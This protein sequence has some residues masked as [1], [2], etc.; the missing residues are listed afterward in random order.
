MDM[1]RIISNKTKDARK[2]AKAL[3][4]EIYNRNHGIKEIEVE[5]DEV[6]CPYCNSAISKNATTCPFC[7]AKYI[8][9]R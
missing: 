9:K 3:E 8:N 2:I 6:L 4:K 7:K 1:Y 5:S